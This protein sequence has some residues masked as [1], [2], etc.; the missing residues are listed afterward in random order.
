MTF[1]E[2]YELADVHRLPVDP[3]KIADALGVKVVSYKSA[4]EF[5]ELDIRE[6]YAQFP[7]GFSFETEGGACVAL[8]ENSC[9]ER[10]RRF[11]AAHE[12]GHCVLGHLDG[13]EYSAE[14]ERA[15]ERFAAELLAPLVVL[16]EHGVRSF[17]EI[18]KLCGISRQAAEL[19]LEELILR[20]RS[21]FVPDEDEQR[22]KKLFFI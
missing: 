11:T 13:N 17:E 3:I 5:F 22:I 1:S 21:G 7:L 6:L 15:A 8:N 4:A 19:R 10:R 20:E 12:L 16:H 2:I 9:G 18:A 14:E